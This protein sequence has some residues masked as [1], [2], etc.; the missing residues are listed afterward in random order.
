MPFLCYPPQGCL[1]KTRFFWN[2]DP[3]LWTHQSIPIFVIFGITG[4]H[5]VQEMRFLGLWD[6]SGLSHPHPTI[7]WSIIQ[8][9]IF[10]FARLPFSLFS[11]SVLPSVQI[12]VILKGFANPHWGTYYFCGQLILYKYQECVY[13]NNKNIN[14]LKASN[15]IPYHRTSGA[16]FCPNG[17]ILGKKRNMF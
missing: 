6:N 14:Q 3:N 17:N 4:G 7:F 8:K 5:Y 10:F 15:R 11:S 2:I 12:G 9:K 16:R 1:R 13:F